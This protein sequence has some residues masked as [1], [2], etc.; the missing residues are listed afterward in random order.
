[1][2]LALV[3]FRG[4]FRVVVLLC[5][6]S[7]SISNLGALRPQ[8][9]TA[10]LDGLDL[11][12]GK[13]LAMEALGELVA[14]KVD[15]LGGLDRRELRGRCA[16]NAGVGGGDGLA[17]RTKLLGVVAVRAKS[18]VRRSERLGKL[19]GRRRR[20]RLGSVVNRR[21]NGPLSKE[22]DGRGALG[23]LGSLAQDSGGIHRGGGW[24]LWWLGVGFVGSLGSVGNGRR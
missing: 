4:V 3:C 12:G 14:V 20:M 8:G 2:S 6:Q 22:L 17:Q 23:V 16:A 5:V 9:S 15:A 21:R 11:S 7:A 24:V 1:M 18:G 19:V 10:R 13:G